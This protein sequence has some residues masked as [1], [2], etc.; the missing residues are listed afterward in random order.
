LHQTTA[1]AMM[2]P[3]QM[4][5][6]RPCPIGRHVMVRTSLETLAAVD[7]GWLAGTSLR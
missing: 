7:A 5:A 1:G 6:G 2:W 4:N 3:P